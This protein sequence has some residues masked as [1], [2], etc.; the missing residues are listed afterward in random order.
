MID[1][2]EERTKTPY[3][4]DF[5]QITTR[6]SIAATRRVV[7]RFPQHV[8]NGA[9]HVK[10]CIVA[11][12]SDVGILIDLWWLYWFKFGWDFQSKPLQLCCKVLQCLRIPSP[13]RRCRSI[14][15]GVSGLPSY[16]CA[17][18]VCVPAVIGLL[19]VWWHNKPFLQTKKRHDWSPKVTEEEGIGIAS[20]VVVRCRE[21]HGHLITAHHS[22]AFSTFREG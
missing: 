2:Q 17:P 3:L 12:R 5:N 21:L 8:T 11:P 19:A 15:S 22:Y 20:N 14:Q 4:L 16:Y 13:L 9:Y 1:C 7:N 6:L 10:V 18:L